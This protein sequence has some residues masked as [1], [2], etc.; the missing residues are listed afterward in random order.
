[1][2]GRAAGLLERA[3]AVVEPADF[4]WSYSRL[5]ETVKHVFAQYYGPLVRQAVEAGVELSDYARAFSD[6]MVD[7]TDDWRV[8]IRARAETAE[9]HRRLGELLG[10]YDYLLLPPWL[11]RPTRRATTSSTTAR[12]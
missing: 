9:L 6:S 11:R 3:G 7:L 1:V 2:S 8:R 12:S 10:R 4:P 5:F